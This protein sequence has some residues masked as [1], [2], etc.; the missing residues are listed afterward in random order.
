MERTGARRQPQQDKKVDPIIARNQKG[1]KPGEIRMKDPKT[2]KT[3]I[4]LP[5]AVLYN[6]FPEERYIE[7]ADRTVTRILDGQF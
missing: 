5:K 3:F 4:K 2:G 6:P 1:L 7:G